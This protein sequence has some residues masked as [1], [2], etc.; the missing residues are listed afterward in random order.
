MGAIARNI[1][2]VRDIVVLYP[3]FWVTAVYRP[4]LVVTPEGTLYINTTAPWTVVL[5]VHVF[6]FVESMRIWSRFPLKNAPITLW[7]LDLPMLKLSEES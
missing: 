2:H 5:R 7:H 1:G 3:G 4:P 6:Y